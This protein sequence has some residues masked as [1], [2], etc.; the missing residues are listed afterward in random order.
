VRDAID[1]GINGQIKSQL[2]P[3]MTDMTFR[4]HTLR[5]TQDS[6]WWCTF[7]NTVFGPATDRKISKLEECFLPALLQKHL[8]DITITDAAGA[9]APLVKREY[10]LFKSDRLP[11]LSAPP[12]WTIWYFLAGLLIGVAIERSTVWAHR[13]RAGRLVFGAL[14][15]ICLIYLSFF[16]LFAMWMWFFSNHWAAWRNENLLTHS[17]IAVALV[18]LIPAIVRRSKRYTT[19]SLNLG[20]ALAISTALA[21]PAALLLPQDMASPTALA[22]PI[23]LAIAWSIR[24]YVNQQL[25]ITIPTTP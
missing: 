2:S 16:A 3:Q 22:L 20:Y 9:Q 12:R 24:R 4:L 21:L 19:I 6:V 18:L 25:T 14:A 8:R 17:P 15:M 1:N 13:A 10:T 7:F 11:E 23:N 5:V